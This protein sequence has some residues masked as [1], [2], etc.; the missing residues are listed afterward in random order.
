[1]IY[2]VIPLDDSSPDLLETVQRLDPRAYVAYGPR[3]YFVRFEGN[4]E[5]LASSIGFTDETRKRAGIVMSAEDGFG[6]GHV[7]LWNW[8]EK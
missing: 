3:I 7:A 4:S 8:M 5:A 6:Y 2:A 1:M